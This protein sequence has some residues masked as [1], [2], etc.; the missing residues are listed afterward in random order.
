M[1]YCLVFFLFGF[2]FFSCSCVWYTSV[3]AYMC[4]S[5]QHMYVLHAFMKNP[6]ASHQVSSLITLY[7]NN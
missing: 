7:F 2:I 5:V 1:F 3:W 6:G 4:T